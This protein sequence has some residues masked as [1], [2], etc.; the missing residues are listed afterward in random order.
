VLDGV[1]LPDFID[2]SKHGTAE[3]LLFVYRK[4][5]ETQRL[6]R[7][8]ELENATLKT[9]L[10]TAQRMIP[11]SKEYAE[12]LMHAYRKMGLAQ[13]AEYAAQKQLKTSELANTALRDQ[14]AA[15]RHQV[16]ELKQLVRN[17]DET[18]TQNTAQH[19]MLRRD[20]DS[21]HRTLLRRE[22]EA[23]LLTAKSNLLAQENDGLTRLRA[24]LESDYTSLKSTIKGRDSTI[25]EL[26]KSKL[27]LQKKLDAARFR[28]MLPS[29]S[30]SASIASS[31]TS[32]SLSSSTSQLPIRTDP[33]SGGSSGSIA[34]SFLSFIGLP[35][36]HS[37][38]PLPTTSMTYPAS[39]E[40]SSADDSSSSDLLL[41]SYSTDNG[42]IFKMTDDGDG[43]C[44][45]PPPEPEHGTSSMMVG[46][47]SL[48]LGELQRR[49]ETEAT[50]LSL[51]SSDPSTQPNYS[52]R[53]ATINGPI[54]PLQKSSTS[55]FASSLTNHSSSPSIGRHA[56][57]S[58]TT[59]LSSA[60]PPLNSSHSSFQ[61]FS[62]TN[63][64]SSTSPNSLSP[65][66]STSSLP[67]LLAPSSSSLL[68]LEPLVFDA[69]AEARLLEIQ[70]KLDDTSTSWSVSVSKSNK[71]FQLP[72][73]VLSTI[74]IKSKS[75]SSIMSTCVDNTGLK[76][77]AAGEN[78]LIMYDALNGS[79]Q[80]TF[81]G[82][83]KTIT[84]VCFDDKGSLILASSTDNTARVWFP[85]TSVP[86]TINHP[87]EVHMAAFCGSDGRIATISRN[88]TLSIWDIHSASSYKFIHSSSQ[89]SM[90]Y[91][92]CV[93]PIANLV[94]TGHLDRSIRVF[95]AKRGMPISQFDTA[96]SDCITGLQISPDGSRIYSTSRDST[97][98]C[99]DTASNKLLATYSTPK[100]RIENNWTHASLSPTGEH[101]A[102][103][104]VT[105]NIFIWD[106][107]S[108][109]LVSTLNAAMSSVLGVSWNPLN[110]NNLI[111]FD[112]QGV[113]S[114]WS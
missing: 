14:V 54:T 29:P 38:Q 108:S 60:S 13:D 35:P 74:Q 39:A 89:K 30:S 5:S 34:N 91:A 82:P 28:S 75:K 31:T 43:A 83:T 69:A 79:V 11:D 55:N 96:H 9:R 7:T 93:N 63:G 25:V 49:I 62:S 66:N 72:T 52:R 106:T 100:L 86:C 76:L 97:I 1:Q 24:R 105:G 56:S 92:M 101:I 65:S 84:S 8:V 107:T 114:I 3:E 23:K 85:N 98:C 36:K 67:T 50:S 26:Q 45:S 111:S 64:F 21:I 112:D 73:K 110:Y 104:S 59:E 78:P 44:L 57:S 10:E 61:S 102:I 81:K 16:D 19:T 88:R 99:Y 32:S 68:L 53:A 103:G 70:R 77:L 109:K 95:D 46:R 12:E 37:T 15:F 22:E 48:K 27:E 47:A 51:L 71:D 20:M 18:I 17:K 94:Y 33:N 87:A 40:P 58:S 42:E 6:L 90:S 41:P 113:I 80:K 2:H 4:L